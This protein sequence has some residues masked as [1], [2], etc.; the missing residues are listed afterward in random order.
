VSILATQQNSQ[1]Q[2]GGWTPDQ[3]ALV[4]S[5]I[6]YA[7]ISDDELAYFGEVCQQT[8]LSPFQKQIYAI[9]REVWNSETQRKE[10]KMTI[11]VSIDGFRLAAARSNLY[12]GSQSFW[13]GEDGEWKDVWLS[14][15]PPAAA[16]TVVYRIGSPSPFI[17]VARFNSYKQEYK[18]KLSKFWESMPDAMIGKVSE[19]LALR[20]AFPAEL[21]GVYAKEEM[22]QAD[23]DSAP[24]PNAEEVARIKADRDLKA[25]LFKSAY[26]DR[27]IS[28]DEAIKILRSF[29]QSRNPHPGNLTDEQLIEITQ[30][31][32]WLAQKQKE[33]TPIIEAEAVF[34]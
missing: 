6:A 2:I 26:T 17:A 15:T 11:Q 16:K 29:D 21:S 31:F 30:Q 3:L 8:G 1:M 27:G 25:E 22:D 19:A 12:G 10:P 18:G 24:Q 4:K 28:R 13:C 23:N 34:V 9:K 32:E 20:K 7:G 14:S 33:A 5:Q